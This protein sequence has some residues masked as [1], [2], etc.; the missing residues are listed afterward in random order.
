MPIKFIQK[1]KSR[2]GFS[3]TGGS[4]EE[5]Y[6]GGRSSQRRLRLNSGF[7][8]IDEILTDYNRKVINADTRY[9]VQS[10]STLH[11]II[12]QKAKYINHGGWKIRSESNDYDFKDI[13]ESDFKSYDSHFEVR[14]CINYSDLPKL[15]SRLLD[16]DGEVFIHLTE[17]DGFPKIQIIESFRVSDCDDIER[18][19]RNCY[20][21]DGLY[22]GRLIHSGIIVDEFGHPVAYRI[23]CDNDQGYIDV[24][25]DQIVHLAERE[26]SQC[27]GVSPILPAVLDFYDIL[28]TRDAEKIAIKTNSQINLIK[29]NETGLHDFGSDAIGP[30]PSG[31]SLEGINEGI[32]TESFDS[33]SIHYVKNGNKFESFSSSRPGGSWIEFMRTIESAAI[34]GMGW[35]R[36]LYESSSLSTAGVRAVSLDVNRAIKERVEVIKPAMLRI[37]R[38]LTSKLAEFYDYDLPEDWYKFEYN[39]IPIFTIDESRQNAADISQLKAGLISES[40]I[41]SRRGQNYRELL[42]SR[43]KDLAV[44]KEVAAE[45]G[46]DPSELGTLADQVVDVNKDDEEDPQK[47]KTKDKKDEK[48]I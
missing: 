44:K 17:I 16:I 31:G 29:Y 26:F 10:S 4:I 14:G 1:V 13:I 41:V 27:H 20:V 47:P 45:Y 48:D 5:Y 15:L 18:D 43:A 42:V 21:S 30:G 23:Q 37:S 3:S 32:E 46:L 38:Y 25:S 22:Q 33:G 28:E 35:R 12:N 24:P 2:L 36:E 9:L 7:R 11:G 8:D 39:Q 40:E 34:F 6:P 19:G